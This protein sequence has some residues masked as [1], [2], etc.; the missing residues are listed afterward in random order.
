MRLRRVIKGYAAKLFQSTHPVWDA[1]LGDDVWLTYAQVSIHASRVGCDRDTAPSSSTNIQFQSTHP[2]WDATCSWRLCCG[3]RGGFN[4]RIPCGMRLPES[5][6]AGGALR[7]QSTHPVW[8]ATAAR[9]ESLRYIVF[10]ST[11]PVWDATLGD[12]V[13]LTYAQVSIHASRVG[14]DFRRKRTTLFPSCFNPRIP[15][16]MRQPHERRKQK[17]RGFNPRIPCGMRPFSGA[18]WKRL[19]GFQSTHPVWDATERDCG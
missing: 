9:K 5:F 7:F 19:V 6:L 4:P 13:W 18:T 17:K 16:G 12:D 15:C 3:G 2:V 14:C 11:H 1:T 10:Q 8:D